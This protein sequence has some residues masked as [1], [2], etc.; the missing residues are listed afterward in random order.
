MFVTSKNSFVFGSTSRVPTLSSILSL[1]YMTFHVEPLVFLGTRHE[2]RKT[3]N[4]SADSTILRLNSRSI[5]L[6]LDNVA[7]LFCSKLQKLLRS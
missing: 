6:I 4:F 2:V 3:F 7:F 1:F 5:S